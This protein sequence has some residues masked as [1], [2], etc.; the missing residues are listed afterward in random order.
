MLELALGAPGGARWQLRELAESCELHAACC[1]CVLELLA[2]AACSVG[3]A[4]SASGGECLR[5]VSYVLSGE[6][7]VVGASARRVFLWL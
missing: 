4:S 7:W 5:R 2:L 6:S 3:G 1:V